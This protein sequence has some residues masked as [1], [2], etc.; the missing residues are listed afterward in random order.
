MERHPEGDIDVIHKPKV[1]TGTPHEEPEEKKP[2]K[3]KP[4]PRALAQ[5]AEKI[6]DAIEVIDE[7]RALDTG[8]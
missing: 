3:T 7:Q 2:A 8:A 4:T 1:W 6:P 5:P